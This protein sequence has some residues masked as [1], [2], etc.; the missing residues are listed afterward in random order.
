MRNSN[1]SAWAVTHQTLVLFLILMV[2]G[3]GALSY[4]KLGRDEDPQF[5]IKTAIV[6]GTQV[7][8]ET[9]LELAIGG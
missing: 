3:A 1:L 2:A 5:T 7:L 8:L 4:F 6:A 9:A